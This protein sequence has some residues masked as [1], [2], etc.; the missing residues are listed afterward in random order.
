MN[1]DYKDRIKG[2]LYAFAI[3]DSMGATTEFMTEEEI[4]AKY[5]RITDIVGGGCLDLKAGECTDD[6]DMS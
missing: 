6:T 1:A 2:A 3:G 4:T 5:G